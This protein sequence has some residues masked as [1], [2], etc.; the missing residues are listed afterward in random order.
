MQG[1]MLVAIL[2]AQFF[3]SFFPWLQHAHT[4][5]RLKQQSLACCSC[6]PHTFR[7]QRRN[8]HGSRHRLWARLATTS[9]CV[10]KSALCR[11][12]CRRAY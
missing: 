11:G 5:R 9:R 10:S 4:N 6:T 8:R 2:P 3:Q 1:G 12:I 7:R